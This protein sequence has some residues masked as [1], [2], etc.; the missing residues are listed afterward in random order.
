MVQV[1]LGGTG[2][3]TG[4]RRVAALG[5]TFSSIGRIVARNVILRIG[6]AAFFLIAILVQPHA[7]AQSVSILPSYTKNGGTECN[8]A[9]EVVQ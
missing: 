7:D 2:V 5:R 4:Y 1:N 6:V 3:L 8:A 9:I